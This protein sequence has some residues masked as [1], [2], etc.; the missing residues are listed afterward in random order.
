MEVEMGVHTATDGTGIYDGH[1]PSLSLVNVCK[2]VARTT[3]TADV[4][5]VDA[6]V[7]SSTDVTPSEG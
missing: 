2:G 1:Q 4:D 6:V 3:A 5:A 7:T